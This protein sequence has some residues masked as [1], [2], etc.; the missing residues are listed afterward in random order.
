[1]KIRLEDQESETR[2]ADTKFKFTLDEI[3]K[4]KTSFNT[5]RSGWTEERTTLIHRAEKAEASLQEMTT[6]L[7]SLKH[8]ISQIVSAIF[9]KQ[10]C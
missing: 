5:K 3:E 10:Y 7:T 9:G 8:H 1:M 4:M 6:E 2:K